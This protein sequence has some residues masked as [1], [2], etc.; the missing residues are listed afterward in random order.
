MPAHNKR[1]VDVRFSTTK[2]KIGHAIKNGRPHVLE[3]AVVFIPRFKW[4][5]RMDG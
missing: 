1:W 3:S 2:D 4:I 5:G